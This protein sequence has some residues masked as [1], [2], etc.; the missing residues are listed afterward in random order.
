[1]P[2]YAVTG[3]AVTSVAAFS[4]KSFF[5]GHAD[6]VV[7]TFSL[8]GD[9]ALLNSFCAPEYVPDPAVSRGGDV[10]ALA[11]YGS[12]QHPMLAVG[13]RDGTI[14][15][16]HADSGAL[17][18]E[19]KTLPGLTQLLSLHR[20]G[21]IAAVHAGKNTLQLWDLDCDRAGLLDFSSELESIHRKSSQMQ[22]T[23]YDDARGVILCGA[24]DGSVFV[25]EVS[26][27]QGTNDLA[28][29]LARF[30]APSASATAP[31]KVR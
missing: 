28:V 17:A 11:V 19:F 10:T 7:R 20:F 22:Y 27:I 8:S 23:R 9:G 13:H 24:D 18:A 6:G 21:A 12:A 2:R 3:P 25:R 15:N 30:N 31:S 16:F 14:H 5:A 4:T 26:R 29:K 1:M